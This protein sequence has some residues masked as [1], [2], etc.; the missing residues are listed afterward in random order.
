MA[1][2]SIILLGLLKIPVVYTQNV[3][4]KKRRVFL[5]NLIYYF[6]VLYRKF[7]CAN[8]AIVCLNFELKNFFFIA[9]TLD[10]SIGSPARFDHNHI[11]Y[12]TKQ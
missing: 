8:I 5:A 9:R 6:L 10:L 4:H 1:G 12:I 2:N 3:M 11:C 7:I